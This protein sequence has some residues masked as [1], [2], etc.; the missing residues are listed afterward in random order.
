[1]KVAIIGAGLSGLA[2]A[3]EIENLADIT[4][5]E[6]ARSVA[7]RLSTKK[8]GEYSF[9]LGAQCFTI[10]SKRIYSYFLKHIENNFLT[11]WDGNVINFH[12]KNYT[13]R[14][15]KEDHYVFTPAMSAFCSEIA[16]EKN[17]RLSTQIA[18]AEFLNKK[19]ILHD[20]ENNFL[21]E[22]DF[23]IS[24]AP[25]NQTIKLLDKYIP[26][27][28]PIRNT[29]MKS[30]F[31]MVVGSKEV[32]NK[33]WIAARV[34]QDIIKW[35]FINS[36]KPYRDNSKTEIIVHASN[37]WSI[38][39]I[40]ENIPSIQEKLR[41]CFA[42]YVDIEIDIIHTHRWLYSIIDKSFKTGPIYLPA[43]NLG[44]TGDWSYTSR[45]E[46]VVIAALEIAD[47]IKGHEIFSKDYSFYGSTF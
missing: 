2:A 46:E 15:W 3:C 9:D 32:W 35:I 29:R 22:F 17:V 36:T 5:F 42:K 37:K 45:V 4:I 7:G 19:W 20:K 27:Y 34:H 18:K 13:N 6:K 23:L 40:D 41:E 10:R 39:N 44:L 47:I 21:G 24:T 11:K 28:S 1:M 30:N 16:K 26:E 25:S 8:I 38:K 31:S 43:Y 14:L 12:N 33:D